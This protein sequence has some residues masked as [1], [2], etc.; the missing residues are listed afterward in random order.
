MALFELF[1]TSCLEFSTLIIDVFCI[2][3]I[4]IRSLWC[5]SALW[6][7]TL[8]TVLY[9]WIVKIIYY[10]N[11]RTANNERYS[12]RTRWIIC[13]VKLFFTGNS[14]EFKALFKSFLL[15][16]S[17]IFLSLSFHMFAVNFPLQKWVAGDWRDFP[18]RRSKKNIIMIS[19]IYIM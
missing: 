15:L 7:K 3:I 16:I 1:N 8:F 13:N 18:Q 14:K 11:G 5:A 10:C 19:K 4:I 2:L 12:G 17:I 9:Y 6:I